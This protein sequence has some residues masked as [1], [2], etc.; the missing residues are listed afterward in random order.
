MAKTTQITIPLTALSVGLHGPFSSGD[1]PSDLTG[2][3]I[4]FQ[5]DVTWPASGDVMTVQ[6]DQSNDSGQT[7]DFVAAITPVGGQW[8]DRQGQPINTTYWNISLNNQG[9]MTRRVRVSL[10]VLQAFNLGIMVSSI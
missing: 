9:S 4:D 10:N 5:N 2:Y 8:V 3:A 7:W 1:L 6:V